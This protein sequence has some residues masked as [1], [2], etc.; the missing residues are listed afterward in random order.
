MLVIFIGFKKKKIIRSKHFS[1]VLSNLRLEEIIFSNNWRKVVYK[2][3]AIYI[4]KCRIYFILVLLFILLHAPNRV[5]G[6]TLGFRSYYIACKDVE[7]RNK[8]LKCSEINFEKKYYLLIMHV[9]FY[10]FSLR[11]RSLS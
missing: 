1:S 6:K 3:S 7:V 11:D 9:Q 10:F 5:N 2:Q 4:Y 8:L